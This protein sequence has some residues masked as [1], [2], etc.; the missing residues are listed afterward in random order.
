MKTDPVI[1]V[2]LDRETRTAISTRE[3]A[4]HLGRAVPTLLEWSCYDKGPIRPL[5][6]NGRLLWP[7]AE[8]RRLLGVVEGSK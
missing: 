1:V 5:R 6:V 2:P 7:V 8:L 4:A 3:A